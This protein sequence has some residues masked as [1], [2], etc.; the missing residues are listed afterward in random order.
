[1]QV[2][3]GAL[4]AQAHA[5]HSQPHANL[6]LA[7]ACRFMADTNR[8]IG[9]A[10]LLA[11]REAQYCELQCHDDELQAWFH[12]AHGVADVARVSGEGVGGTEI[13]GSCESYCVRDS[14]FWCHP[15]VCLDPHSVG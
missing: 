11:M 8:A 4:L 14:D 1:M 10:M 13:P 9:E 6:D 5:N 3:S 7:L 15:D 2:S 12:D